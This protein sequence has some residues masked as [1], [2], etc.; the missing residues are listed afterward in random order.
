MKN[1]II[2]NLLA[3]FA[4]VVMAS[5][6]K[7]LDIE[8]TQSVDET[9]ALNTS[10]DVE[11]ALVGAYAL[12]GDGDVQGGNSQVNSE[13]LGNFD[14]INWSGTFQG[15]TQIFNKS[16]PVNN[17]FV[18]NTW[19]DSYA[20]INTINNVLGALDK[21][22]ETKKD[23][24][25]GEAKFLR[26][27]IYF[28]LVKLFGKD[29]TDGDPNVNLGVPLVLEPTRDINESSQVAR[30]TVA[31]V[32]TQIINDL[33][34]AKS[35][36]TEP[37]NFFADQYAASA[38]LARVYLQQAE[39]AL[40]LEEANNVINT[41]GRSL[42][43]TYAENFPGEPGVNPF[44]RANTDEEIFAL[45][46]NATTG[47]N[48]FNT[49]FSTSGRGDID[50]TDVHLSLYE[51]NDDRLNLF[52]DQNA[53]YTGKYENIYGNVTIVR[54]AEMYLIRAECNFRLG[55]EVGRPPLEDINRIRARA[56]LLPLVVLDLD[57]ILKERKLE[58]AFEG[59]ALDDA[60]RLKHD[61]GSLP[62]NSNALVYP[63]PE[64]ELLVNKNLVQN[65]GY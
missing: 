7:R 2:Y 3:L 38:I 12:T 39:Y 42:L 13:L 1:R 46:V 23:R 19:T 54:L 55:T 61:V 24:V 53:I 29:Y 35:K 52:Y 28:N 21:V 60:K 48:D 43:T 34:D 62:Y 9:N 30:A 15:M 16:I 6:E 25:E 51:P 40:A 56:K 63:I 10:S 59:F 22:D 5:C 14:E 17:T 20:A 58:L 64:R 18:T 33:K 8:P 41:S 49:Y 26:A 32:Y 4:V 47:V 57:A 31:A 36:I 27:L 11:A 65:P 45:Q 50:I 37:S 44:A